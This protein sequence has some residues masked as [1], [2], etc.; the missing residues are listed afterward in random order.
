MKDGEEIRNIFFTDEF[1]EFRESLDERSK[2]KLDDNVSIL[3]TVYVLSTK[4]VKKIVNTDLYEMRV[5]VG[6]N[7]YRSILFAIDHKNVIQATKIILLNGFL[8]KS[9]KDYDKHI[10]RAINILNNSEL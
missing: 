7:E 1:N 8:K 9:S 10:K 6:F 3:K 2:E 4:F 5:S